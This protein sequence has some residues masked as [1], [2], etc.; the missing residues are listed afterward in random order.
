ME[1][2]MTRILLALLAL[3]A[4]SLPASAAAQLHSNQD[5]LRTLCSS[6]TMDY[7]VSFLSLDIE[8]GIN[9]PADNSDEMLFNA[10][11]ALFGKSFDAWDLTRG[12]SLSFEIGDWG[13]RT[14]GA[15]IATNVPG[16]YE[17]PDIDGGI[18]SPPREV[19]V[20][21]FASSIVGGVVFRPETWVEVSVPE[22]G[23]TLLLLSGLLGLS[24]IVRR[25]KLAI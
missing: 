7:C 23:T 11:I 14:L 10:S 3:G 9:D 12:H 2:A 19:T 13:L 5:P 22:P 21:D 18:Q 15:I 8:F 1:R 6:H 17:F 16:V 4:I 24:L 20:D 25:Q